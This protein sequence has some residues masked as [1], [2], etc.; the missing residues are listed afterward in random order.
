VRSLS[1]LESW[2]HLPLTCA[3]SPL[4]SWVDVDTRAQIAPIPGYP[5]PNTVWFRIPDIPAV[6][7]V[8]RLTAN[9][10]AAFCE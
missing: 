6:E 3:T 7:D 9:V 5:A 8:A 4:H 1:L 2:G 10:A